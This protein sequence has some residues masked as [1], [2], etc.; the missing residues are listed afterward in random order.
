[1]GQ[2]RTYAPDGLRRSLHQGGS[3]NPVSFVWDGDDL[4][5][6][7]IGGGVSVRY[8]VLDGEVFGERRD[9]SRYLCVPDP[10]GSINHLLDTGQTIAG[11][12]IYAPYGE[13]QSHTGA[14]TPMQFVGALGYYT[15]TTNRIYIR[16]R[17]YRPDLGRTQAELFSG[18]PDH[19]TVAA[20]ALG[21]GAGAC[22]RLGPGACFWCYFTL[23]S[24]R[25][26][27]CPE[28]ACETA[29][30]A[31]G[32]HVE[33]GVCGPGRAPDAPSACRQL[34]R[35]SGGPFV[36]FLRGVGGR[37]ACGGRQGA[38]KLAHCWFHC[39][40]G[41]CGWLWGCAVSL[42][43]D[44]NDPDDTDANRRGSKCALRGGIPGRQGQECLKCCGQAVYRFRCY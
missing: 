22:T 28:R 1:M 40:A 11:T 20:S 42:L 9:A 25:A 13:V 27:L 43:P 3:A 19:P 8:D 26:H 31:C 36:E 18:G 37:A 15:D 30:F 41:R 16:A 29:R 32:S 35:G 2:H 10:L 12:Y 33:C 5:N 38:D 14:N 39:M 7:Y 44:P 21:G 23:L 6:D 17:H 34:L 4:L 24:E